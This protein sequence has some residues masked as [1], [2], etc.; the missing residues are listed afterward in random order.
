MPLFI[1][2]QV[3]IDNTYPFMRQFHSFS[4]LFLSDQAF[5]HK[6]KRVE[7]LDFHKITKK[8]DYTIKEKPEFNFFN[9]AKDAVKKSE[10]PNSKA[11]TILGFG[12]IASFLYMVFAQF[13]SVMSL[14]D[15]PAIKDYQHNI[16]E[17]N[18][19][20]A[21]DII[22]GDSVALNNHLQTLLKSNNPDNQF[23]AV[24][25]IE[26][27]SSYQHFSLSY[28]NDNGQRDVMDASYGIN[29]ITGDDLSKLVH[30]A[31][32]KNNQDV[33][34]NEFYQQSYDSFQKIKQ[35]CS[36]GFIPG[37]LLMGCRMLDP[38]TMAQNLHGDYQAHI[39]TLERIFAYYPVVEQKNNV[40]SNSDSNGRGMTH[41]HNH[42]KSSGQKHHQVALQ[43]N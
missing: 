39:D 41:S 37:S 3:S 30:M 7:Q 23:L 33:L 21:H 1:S 26:G 14:G 40:H 8:S 20:L 2:C 4:G 16:E 35:S 36:Y 17:Q 9:K 29:M 6:D 10:K 42:S 24:Q 5:Y 38:D 27:I 31:I 34:T 25:T 22:K 12:I 28:I 32:E 15:N 43:D 19:M 18:N 13:G 11:E